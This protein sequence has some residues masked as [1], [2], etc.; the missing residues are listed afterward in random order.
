[1]IEQAKKILREN[2][3]TCVFVKDDWC[4]TSIDRGVA[5][6]L[7]CLEQNNVPSG[8]CAADKVVGKA[9]AFLYVLLKVDTLYTDV[10]SE[11]ALIVL[12]KYNIKVEAGEVVK[13][14]R[15]RTDTGYCPMETAVWEIDNPEEA[16][17]AI[18]KQR[19]LL[20]KAPA[21]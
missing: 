15:N 2:P 12:K 7:Q 17:E 21:E 10:I 18:I 6:L 5:P 19:E 9:A 20:R 3:Y 4:F 8:F 11:P 16:L 14:I 13:A 1:M